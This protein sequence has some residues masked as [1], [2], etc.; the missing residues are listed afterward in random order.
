MTATRPRAIDRVAAAIFARMEQGQALTR[1][2]MLRAAADC[3]MG[4]ELGARL[5]D[6]IIAGNL[7]N[8]PSSWVAL[9]SGSDARYF[10]NAWEL[11]FS[12]R[13]AG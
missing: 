5:V 7:D 8:G 1:A 2:D 12:A 4:E 9:G 6:K 13:L 10:R 3:N 11:A